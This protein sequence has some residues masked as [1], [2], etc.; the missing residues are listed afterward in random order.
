MS[1][2]LIAL[3][4]NSF[5]LILRERYDQI[6]DGLFARVIPLLLSGCHKQ[7]L[8]IKNISSSPPRIDPMVYTLEEYQNDKKKYDAAVNANPQKV[9]DAVFWRNTIVYGLTNDIDLL[10][11]RTYSKTFGTKNAVAIAGDATVL[12][13]GAAGSIATNTATKTIFAALSTAFTGL[14]TSIDKNLYAQQ[15]FQILGLAMQTRR[16]KTRLALYNSLKSDLTDYPLNAAKRD[17]VTYL[18][19][20]TLAAGLQELQEEAGAASTEQSTKTQNQNDSNTP[21]VT[22]DNAKPKN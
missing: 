19:D 6:S 17:L 9:T 11:N 7:T 2:P 5:H 22:I 3:V 16:D 20:G 21:A 1:L 14:N 18:R 12:G 4:V 15:S 10:Y 13:L 8:S